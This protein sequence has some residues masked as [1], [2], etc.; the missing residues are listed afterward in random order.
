MKE[1][2]QKVT[3]SSENKGRGLFY[4]VIAVA[5]MIIMGVG[6]TFAY[7]TATTSSTDTA[8]Q[9]GSTTLQL[10][11]I[12][13]EGAWNSGALIPANTDV[14]E[15]SF[16][17]QSDIT[18][19][20]TEDDYATIRHNALCKDDFGNDICSV[21]VFQVANTAY[22]DQTVSLDVLTTFN[23]FASLYAMAYEISEP[24]ES[25]NPEE[26]ALY[27]PTEDGEFSNPLNGVG[28]PLFATPIV[29]EEGETMPEGAFAVRDGNGKYLEKD[30]DYFPVYVNRG[31]VIKTMLDYVASED[32]ITK[33]YDRPIK[34]IDGEFPD[35]NSSRIADNITIEGNSVKTFALVLYIKNNEEVDQTE[36]DADKEFMGKIVVGP[37]DGT[38]GVSGQIGAMSSNDKTLYSSPTNTED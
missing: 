2:S 15:Y 26:F 37:G 21:Y 18:V 34:V 33:A 5:V 23:E 28:D 29:T 9:T 31:G 7:F 32:S 24:D 14:V 30:E 20:T 12:S 36:T 17:Y 10:K 35:E 16:T 1:N 25:L 13:Y 38:G 27:F 19:D 4:G 8:V 11:Y 6:A 3:I 22:S